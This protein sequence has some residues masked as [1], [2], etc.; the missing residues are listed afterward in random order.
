[1]KGLAGAPIP[2]EE[3]DEPE[4]FKCGRVGHY[5]NMCHYK[6][7]CVV[8]HGEGHA[9]AHFPT[10]GRPLMLQ[11]MGNAILGEGFFCLP[12]VEAEGEEVRT[13]LA[14]DAVVISAAPGLL[15]VPILEAELPHLFEGEWDWQV[16]AIGD[17]MF[18]VIFPNKAMLRMATRSGKLFLSLNNIM[19]EIKESLRRSPSPRSCR[20]CGSS[21]GACLPNIA[22]WIASWLGL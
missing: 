4:C 15:S 20:T 11:I 7:L 9:S 18:S 2:V 5:Q 12:F 22:V 8:C 21:C 16:T 17:N 10:R 6:P 13:P 19:A 1:M 14:A 3:A